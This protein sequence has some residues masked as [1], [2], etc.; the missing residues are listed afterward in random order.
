MNYC[1]FLSNL[2]IKNSNKVILTTSKKK[3]SRKNFLIEINKRRDFF[4][5]KGLIIGQNIL[6]KTKDRLEYIFSFFGAALGGYNVVSLSENSSDFETEKIISLVQIH[7]IHTGFKSNDETFLSSVNIDNRLKNITVFFFT[8]GTTGLPKG[9][10]HDLNNLLFNAMNFNKFVGL[11]D[12]CCMY[13]VLP[14]GYMAGLL[15]TILSPLLT[16]GKIV[17]G[18]VFSAK[19]SL[20]FW[21]LIIKKKVNTLWLTPTIL[22]ILTK[23]KISNSVTKWSKKNVKKIFV[24]TSSLSEIT[25]K[26]FDEK[27]GVNSLE[28]YGMT[29]CMLISVSKPTDVNI[30]SVGY[31]LPGV[32]CKIRNIKKN[33]TSTNSI[34]DIWVKSNFLMKGLI[35]STN[36]K[37]KKINT[38]M[39]FNTGDIGF[40]DKKGRLFITD[41]K[42]DIIIKGGIN[43]S[44]RTIE[45]ALLSFP[46]ISETAVI[47]A[48]SK[49]WGQEINAYII[50]RKNTDINLKDLKYYCEKYLSKNEIPSKFIIL[51]TF[52]KSS[53]G[54][55]KKNLLLKK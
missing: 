53:T 7:H 20:T 36:G 2:I 26:K 16:G 19:S 25:K 24:G 6:I 39:W 28:S 9:I 5:Q 34:G 21:N 40:K 1:E 10:I 38:S 33:I 15:N 44:P 35:N 4:A 17:L 50:P 49:I 55:I 27:F 29:E 47:A 42:K 3:F 32:N 11:N 37:I 54:K 8:S 41:R 22:T 18:D 48:P 46:D 43:I 45:N 14:V 23:L 52:P 12:L 30:N 51:N 13:H 31:P